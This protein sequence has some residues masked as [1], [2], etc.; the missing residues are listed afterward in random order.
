MTSCPFIFIVSNI[1]EG[2]SRPFIGSTVIKWVSRPFHFTGKF[3]NLATKFSWDPDEKSS[4][5]WFWKFYAEMLKNAKVITSLAKLT[6][7][8][9]RT[10]VWPILS[11]FIV[12][13]LNK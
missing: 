10:E 5:H 1:I 6:D 4:L 8:L 7:A 3:W 11:I 12:F 9:K 2:V 13:K